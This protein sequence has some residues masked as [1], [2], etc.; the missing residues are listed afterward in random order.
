MKKLAIEVNEDILEYV[1]NKL[2]KPIEMLDKEEVRREL[3]Q[4]IEEAI[5]G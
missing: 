1:A 2:C 5:N 4:I 3:Q